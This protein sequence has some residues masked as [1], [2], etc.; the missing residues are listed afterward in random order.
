MAR[1]DVTQIDN[2]G[3]NETGDAG[4]WKIA[5]EVSGTQIV[6]HVNDMICRLSDL[7][8]GELS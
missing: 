2:N 4:V 8:Y 6:V 1:L 3:R 5:D 7:S